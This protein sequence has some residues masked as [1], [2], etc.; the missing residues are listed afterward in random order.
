MKTLDQLKVGESA[1][2]KNVKPSSLTIKLLEMGLM[3]GKI[4]K[5][6]FKAPLGDPISV[7]IAGYNLSLRV[8]EASQ[9]EVS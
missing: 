3:P 2:I 6:N 7:Q 8:D 9:V 4:V 5:F 1:I